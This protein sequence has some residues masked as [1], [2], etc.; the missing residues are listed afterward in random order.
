MQDLMKSMQRIIE[1]IQIYHTKS[2]E[3]YEHIDVNDIGKAKEILNE[4]QKWY[5]Q[6][7]SHFDE[8]KSHEDPVVLCSHIK[9]KRNVSALTIL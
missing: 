7:V 5:D 6:T 9:R 4:I 2:S 8:L 3:K 1:A